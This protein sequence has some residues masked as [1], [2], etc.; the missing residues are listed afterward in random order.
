[1]INMAHYCYYW[2]S[3]YYFRF[4]IIKILLVHRANNLLHLL[5][6]RKFIIHFIVI[7]ILLYSIE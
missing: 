6:N 2:W 4:L 3:S 1:M 7:D 5:I